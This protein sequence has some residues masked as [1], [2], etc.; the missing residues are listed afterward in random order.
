MKIILATHNSGK[1]LEFKTL[2]QHLEI[3]V[4]P[5]T[6]YSVNEIEESGLSFIENALLKARHATKLTGLPALADD[7]GLVVDVLGGEPG[8]YSARYAGKNAD[9]NANIQKL[10]ANLETIPSE[11]RHAEFHCV[12]VLM[13]YPEDP[14]PLICH[15]KW[16]GSILTK[17]RGHDGFGYDPIFF[18]PSENKSAAELSPALKN[19]ISHRAVALQ[20]LLKL[21]PEKLHE[22]SAK[23]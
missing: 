6:E 11:K 16:S 5:Q 9:A 2:L 20:S 4:I 17:P 23:C 14:I 7:S 15:G 12:L 1:T 19:K 21:L 13:L 3:E 8:I 22:Q 18:V 10:L